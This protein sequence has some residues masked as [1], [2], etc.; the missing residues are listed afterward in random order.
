MLVPIDFL[1]SLI[2]GSLWKLAKDQFFM[3]ALDQWAENIN[4]NSAQLDENLAPGQQ[5]YCRPAGHQGNNS[6]VAL[7]M[8]INRATIELLPWWPAGRQ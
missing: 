6:I 5:F 7:L 3:G 2:Q 1:S 8:I 4:R